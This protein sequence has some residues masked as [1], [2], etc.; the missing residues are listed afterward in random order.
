MTKMADNEQP[1]GKVPHKQ[2]SPLKDA[3]RSLE[4]QLASESSS[5]SPQEGASSSS[6]AATLQT[7][8]V[9]VPMETVTMSQASSEDCTTSEEQQHQVVVHVHQEEPMEHEQVVMNQEQ[10]MVTNMEPQQVIINQEQQVVVNVEQPQQVQQVVIHQEQPMAIGEQMLQVIAEGGETQQQDSVQHQKLHMNA[11]PNLIHHQQHPVLPQTGAVHVTQSGETTQ[12]HQEA[13]SSNNSSHVVEGTGSGKDK[14]MFK[15]VAVS[16]DGNPDWSK[17][18]SLDKDILKEVFE[19]HGISMDTSDWPT[20]KDE[21]AE[22]RKKRKLAKKAKKKK[23]KEKSKKSKGSAF[24]YLYLCYY[25]Y[26]YIIYIRSTN[27]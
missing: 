17:V 15:C 5:V 10:P 19:K 24:I 27:L 16:A 11:Q 21:D 3:V 14:T 12:V 9:V 13:P 8:S 2:E 4:A 18:M 22:A 23:K 20:Q 25:M 6:D 1:K 26:I 7:A